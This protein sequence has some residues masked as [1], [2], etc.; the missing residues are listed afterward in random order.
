MKNRYSERLALFSLD[1]LKYYKRKDYIMFK[2]FLAVFLVAVVLTTPFATFVSAEEAGTF[3]VRVPE[4]DPNDTF[5]QAQTIYSDYTINGSFTSQSDVDVY[6]ITSP[7][8]GLANFHLGNIPAAN[9]YD[10]EL[11]DADY[12][13]LAV[14]TASYDFEQIMAY[15]VS[16]GDVFYIL[17]RCFQIY[18]TGNLDYILR[19]RVYPITYTYYSQVAESPIT[20]SYYNNLENTTFTGGICSSVDMYYR[21]NRFGCASASVAM[22]LKNMNAETKI[23]VPD[24]PG[25]TS[26]A[27]NAVTMNGNPYAVMMINSGYWGYDSSLGKSRVIL[28]EVSYSNGSYIVSS[29]QDPAA[30]KYDWIANAYGLTYDFAW[31]LNI[32]EYEKTVAKL[33]SDHPEGI[34]LYFNNGVNEHMCVVTG[35]TME[36]TLTDEELASLLAQSDAFEA[37]MTSQSF[38]MNASVSNPTD[39]SVR[40]IASMQN[41]DK[42]TVYDPFYNANSNSTGEGILLSESYTAT[43][44]SWSDLDYIVFFD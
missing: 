32:T 11:Y 2:K 20:T 26:G 22:V 43:V 35:T 16:V 36:V 42:F 39:A 12:E 13:L 14:G 9:D 38:E 24:I 33:I 10:L 40:S 27:V 15:P 5:A 25:H 41:A 4:E 6:K 19:A 17:V 29:S 7:I 44:F 28:P 37:S 3:A 30:C 1:I 23:A 8:D 18:D 34:C 21:Y 31:G